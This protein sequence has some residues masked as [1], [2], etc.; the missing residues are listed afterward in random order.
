MGQ[1]L[2][3][4][5]VS[6]GTAGSIFFKCVLFPL[7]ALAALPQWGAMLEQE[8]LEQA[9]DVGQGTGCGSPSTVRV[10]ERS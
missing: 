5:Y 4:A 1:I 7:S 9:L 3:T 6:Q 10:P 8:G 2:R